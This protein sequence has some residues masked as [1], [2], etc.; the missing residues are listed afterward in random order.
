M[1]QEEEEDDD[2]KRNYNKYNPKMMEIPQ[3]NYVNINN[4]HRKLLV[5]H[6]GNFH[7]EFAYKQYTKAIKNRNKLNKKSSNM[8]Y[9]SNNYNRNKNRNNK[10]RNN[11]NNKY[12][13]F[14]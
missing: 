9:K 12:S 8:K 10:N 11:R 2:I 7:D 4:K 5:N 13:F 1:D 6:Y 3:V 14:Q